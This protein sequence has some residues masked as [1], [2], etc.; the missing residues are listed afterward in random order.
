[1]GNLL[2]WPQLETQTHMFLHVS[3][4]KQECKGTFVH[5]KIRSYPCA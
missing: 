4:N 1:M 3:M 5:S 2:S